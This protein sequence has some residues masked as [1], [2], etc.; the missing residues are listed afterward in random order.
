MNSF[1]IIK[2]LNGWLFVRSVWQ[3]WIPQKITSGG[4]VCG[5]IWFVV[6]ASFVSFITHHLRLH[7][8]HKHDR[9][10]VSLLFSNQLKATSKYLPFVV[11]QKNT[12]VVT[13]SISSIHRPFVKHPKL[14]LSLHFEHEFSPTKQTTADQTDDNKRVHIHKINRTQ[15]KSMGTFRL[16]DN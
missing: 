16:L 15:S 12:F 1:W 9:V 11:R 3:P 13:F 8:R 6:V 14:Y 2:C 4:A 10:I 7:G 5:F